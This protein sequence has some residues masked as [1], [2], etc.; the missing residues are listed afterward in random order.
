MVHTHAEFSSLG[1]CLR[2]NILSWPSVGLENR[3]IPQVQPPPLPASHPPPCSP[4]QQ[5]SKAKKATLNLLYARNSTVCPGE[6]ASPSEARPFSPNS[7]AFLFSS[8]SPILGLDA[9]VHLFSPWVILAP[10][11]KP[12]VLFSRCE[13]LRLTCPL[14]HREILIIQDQFLC[15]N[16][17]H[18]RV[19]MYFQQ[20]AT[21]PVKISNWIAI[22]PQE[23]DGQRNIGP[24]KAVFPLLLKTCFHFPGSNAILYYCSFSSAV[25]PIKEFD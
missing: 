20:Q 11:L 21:K 1:I 17:W 19:E 4:A 5:I 3:F 18:C 13:S 7:H 25:V 12:P 6:T 8:S 15:V 9:G 22:I 10:L 16:N 24:P 2:K 23:R 14:S